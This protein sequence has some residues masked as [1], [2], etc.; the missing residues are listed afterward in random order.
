MIQIVN[1]PNGTLQYKSPHV[2]HTVK[3]ESIAAGATTAA[4]AGCLFTPI[5]TDKGPT[6]KVKLFTGG[7]AASDMVEMFGQPN[8]RKLG[9][10]YTQ[11]YEHALRGGNVAVVSVKHSSATNAG[12][13]I[14]MV[15]E[16]KEEN[17]TSI[18]K[19]LGWIKLD[20]SAFLEDENANADNK[21]SNVSADHTVHQIESYR[22]KFEVEKVNNIKNI[23]SLKLLVNSKFTAAK[24]N[25]TA[26]KR[27]FPFIFGMYN[28]KGVYGNN[29][30]I[31]FENL[32]R[33]ASGGY[34]YFQASIYD[35]KTSSIV[36]GTTQ[37]VSLSTVRIDSS[38]LFI[39]RRFDSVY[40]TGDYTINCIDN[41]QMNYIGGEIEKLLK[42]ITLFPNTASLAGVEAE[43]MEEDLKDVTALF[44]DPEDDD[45]HK[46]S[47]IDPTNLE[48][49]G[50]Y[51]QTSSMDAYDFSGGSEGILED[52]SKNGWDWERQYNTADSS[53]PV[54][55][56][57]V[58]Q[59]MFV[60]AFTGAISPD[61]FNLLTNPCDYIVDIGYPL[62]V[63][64]AMV[65]FS[66]NRDDVEVLF[67]AP[68]DKVDVNQAIAWKRSFNITGRNI[69]Y[70]TGSFE[71]VD[72]RSDKS[73]RVPTS[74]FYM[75]NLLNHYNTG[76][77]Q[78]VAGI[79]LGAL[80]FFEPNSGR[81]YGNTSLKDNDKLYDAGFNI[82]STHTEGLIYMDS[83]RSNYLL[84]ETSKLQLLHNNSIVNRI[85][86]KLYLL[87]QYEKHRLNSPE[88]VAKIT[89]KIENELKAE[90][91]G[92]VAGLTYS[93]AFE[94]VY[95]ENIG[96]FTHDVGIQLYGE[97]LY[98][99][100][101][102]R[103]LGNS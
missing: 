15:I 43:A 54:K 27:S 47:L 89:G 28:G 86:K 103:A 66:T 72:T 64:K 25:P 3:D 48:D 5:Y 85:L 14:N 36:K 4:G 16:T 7:S 35:R 60:D 13:I 84:T 99:K 23:D 45:F 81:G 68:V 26:N 32:G 10:A 12:F 69:Y 44:A 21:P 37:P 11:A 55:R 76:F 53:Q 94:S 70:Y 88:S 49:V 74:F 18:K 96:M 41:G 9:M 52:L 91:I 56:E 65:T 46:L 71:Y 17:G 79:E 30:R 100:I 87:L 39:E 33:T 31:M 80:S 19:T 92:K 42:K 102:L 73:F 93:G 57:K 62:A 77:M 8:T 1:S 58:L 20:G 2:F 40:S 83:Q 82:I 51:L 61:V 101:L 75:F 90:F 50:K 67:S 63:K 95:A 6:D 59:N 34:P 29:F 78:P 22:I 97:M 24:M 38:P 98:H